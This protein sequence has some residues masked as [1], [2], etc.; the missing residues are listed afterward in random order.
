MMPAMRV[1]E[2]APARVGGGATS[3]VR[4]ASVDASPRAPVGARSLLADRL[5]AGAPSLV[6]RAA[7]A[8]PSVASLGLAS[9]A[10]ASTSTLP[11]SIARALEAA[12][13]LA[14]SDGPEGRERLLTAHEHDRLSA[15]LPMLPAVAA[16]VA[17]LID[18]YAPTTAAATLILRAVYAR[19]S[20]LL[21]GEDVVGAI[22]KFARSLSTLDPAALRVRASV[23]D[24][25]SR[26]STSAIDPPAHSARRGVI[27]AKKADDV[28]T[29]NDGLYQ[30]YSASCGP[31]VIH[32][33][34]AESDPVLSFALHEAGLDT[35]GPDTEAAR[36]QRAVLEHHGGVAVL[37]TD[38]QLW[39][40]FRNALGRVRD[41]PSVSAAGVAALERFVTRK[42]RLTSAALE[43]VD[44]LHARFAFPTRADLDLLRE[45][46]IPARD[47]GIGTEGLLAALDRHVSPTTGVY[48]RETTPAGG[49]ARGQAYRHIDAVARALSRGIDVPFG[50]SEPSHWMLLSAVTGAKPER[51]F[52]MSDPFSGRTAW[53]TEADLKSGVFAARQFDLCIGKERGYVDCFYLPVTTSA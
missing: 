14:K 24:L 46:P 51:S 11:A 1:R 50:I 27:H 6:A 28:R 52:L 21:A 47:E 43:V 32:M 3:G 34:V 18:A 30:R 25:D 42:G 20:R 49:F 31:T 26:V 7:S 38:G 39:S 22:E 17:A 23:L 2:P 15:A 13:R 40:R 8:S 4:A 33:M 37:G 10:S 45:R 41:D 9:A 44:A 12:P 29:D 48:Y 53:V 35:P 16:R 5:T 19:T 36:F